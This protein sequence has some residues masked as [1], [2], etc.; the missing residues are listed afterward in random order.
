MSTCLNPGIVITSTKEDTFLVV[1]VFFLSVCLQNNLKSYQWIL[2]KFSGY[3]ERD[4]RNR[5]ILVLIWITVL[6]QEFLERYFIFAWLKIQVTLTEV[7]I[8]NLS[9]IHTLAKS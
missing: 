9:L 7:S 6:I 4:T 1:I 2:T 5:S 3:V 8:I